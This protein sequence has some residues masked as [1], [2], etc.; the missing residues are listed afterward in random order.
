[1]CIIYI[2][3]CMHSLNI[4]KSPFLAQLQKTS[5]TLA[6]TGAVVYVYVLIHACMHA[7][8]GTLASTVICIHVRLYVRMHACM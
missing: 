5:G 2:Y 8:P 1:M 6:C 7:T 4:L 3:I